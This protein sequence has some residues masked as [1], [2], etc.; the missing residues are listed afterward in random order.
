ME[1]RQS[2]TPLKTYL[3]KPFVRLRLTMNKAKPLFKVIGG[4]PVK[5]SRDNAPS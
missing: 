2:H 4:N 1:Y 5:K 3:G